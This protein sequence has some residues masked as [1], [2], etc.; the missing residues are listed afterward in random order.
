MRV[1]VRGLQYLDIEG[2]V[3]PY[4]PLV[5]VAPGGVSRL[6]TLAPPGRHPAV[7]GA[8][9]QGAVRGGEARRA[10][11][12]SLS[13]REGTRPVTRAVVGT[14]RAVVAG[15]ES[16]HDVVG[17][18]VEDDQH[19]AGGGGEEGGAGL[20]EEV[21]LWTRSDGNSLTRPESVARRLAW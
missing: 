2:A 13:A 1:L 20:E 10:D 9:R 14:G 4:K 12:V 21:K 8:E 11:T 15:A 18:G 16:L 7:A 6:E 19:G 3:V 5:T 17:V